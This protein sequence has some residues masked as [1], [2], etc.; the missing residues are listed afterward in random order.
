MWWFFPQPG[1]SRY[2][3]RAA[4]YNYKEGWWTQGQMS[5]S[6]GITSSYTA[7]TIMADGLVAFEHEVRDVLRTPAM[8]VV[9]PLAETFDL[10]L[11]LG[12]RLTTV[13]QMIPDVEAATSTNL[14]YSLFCQRQLG[15]SA[16]HR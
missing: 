7:H 4:I 15:Q 13:K 11:S 8:P 10:N 9:L 3:T 1:D 5:R 16:L 12:R 14:L 6:A 2:N